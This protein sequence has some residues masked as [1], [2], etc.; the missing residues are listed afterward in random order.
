MQI[1]SGAISSVARSAL[2]AGTAGLTLGKGNGAP[3]A[4]LTGHCFAS[5]YAR[6]RGLTAYQRAQV[7]TYVAQQA[8]VVL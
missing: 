8:G 5:V 7:T 4:A 1:G 2:V 3:T 6:S